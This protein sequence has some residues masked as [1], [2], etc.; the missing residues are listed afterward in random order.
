MNYNVSVIKNV[1][2]HP[3]DEEGKDSYRYNEAGAKFS[4]I[5]NINNETAIFT[6]IKEV[7]LERLLEWLSLG[8]FKSD[9]T[10]TEGFRNL[11]N[12]TVLCISELNEIE[13]QITENVKMISGVIC[14]KKLIKERFKNIPI[15]DIKNQFS[16][17]LKLFNIFPKRS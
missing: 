3:I 4:I 9:L 8:P 1:K 10:F 11:K 13:A 7:N 5:Q 6:K 2:H 17:F 16:E 14:S 12:P 15:I